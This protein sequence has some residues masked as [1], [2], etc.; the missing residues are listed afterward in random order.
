MKPNLLSPSILLASFLMA[1]WGATLAAAPAFF[2]YPQSNGSGGT[3]WLPMYPRKGGGEIGFRQ[4]GPAIEAVDEAGDV[5]WSKTVESDSKKVSLSGGM[6]LDQDGTTDLVLIYQEPTGG[7][8]GPELLYQ[9]QIELRSGET[10]LTLYG[11][12]AQVDKCWSFP[13]QSYPTRQWTNLAPLFGKK[14]F[15]ALQPYYAT[16]GWLFDF[17]KRPHTLGA[18][19]FPSTQQFDNTYPAARVGIKGWSFQKDA[20]VANGL[21]VDQGGESRLIFFTSNRVV[22]YKMTPL[23]PNQLVRQLRYYPGGRGDLSGRNYGLVGQD[24]H[25]PN[26][27]YLIAGSSAATVMSDL[28][29]GRRGATD[30]W[31]QIERHIT[32][33]D[34]VRGIIEDRFFSSAHDN[35]STHKWHKRIAYPANPFVRRSRGTPSRLA[36]NVYTAG[37]WSLHI[38]D[39][40][41]LQDT[42]ALA[43]LFLWDIRDLDGDGI[44][45]WIVSPTPQGAASATLEGY[46]PK[47]ETLIYRWDEG[48]KNLQTVSRFP[49]LPK[50]LP[51]FRSPGT[52]NSSG[53]AYPVSLGPSGGLLLTT[54]S[55][56]VTTHNWKATPE[57]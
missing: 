30:E 29:Q 14:G 5:L 24:P 52:S 57:E 21:I 1:A 9:T 8:C 15:L 11:S 13:T 33:Y 40:G 12:Q 19:L 53:L 35:N 46:F 36:Y 43:G 10:G 6:D 23:G 39:T 37:L 38:S 47:K 27:V 4:V 16:Q 17:S 26:L 55:G 7:S 31:G 41:G 51:R 25:Q 18:Y 2:A 45:E 34:W 20:H 28:Q 48:K 44:D 50:L 42:Y 32:R 56:A 22:D 54:P 3:N 49:G